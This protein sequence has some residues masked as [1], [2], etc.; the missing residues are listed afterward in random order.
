V[1]EMDKSIK[2][3]VDEYWSELKKVIF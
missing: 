2:R 1:V 3:K